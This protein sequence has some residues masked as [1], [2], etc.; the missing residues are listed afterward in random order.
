MAAFPFPGGA[1]A[2]FVNTLKRVSNI[3]VPT[4]ILWGEED[5]VDPPKTA[6]LLFDALCCEKQLHVIPGNGHLGHLDRNK[7]QVFEL[8]ANWALKTLTA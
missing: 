1:E 7:E 6:Q 8:T 2:I 4:L 5:E 3:Q